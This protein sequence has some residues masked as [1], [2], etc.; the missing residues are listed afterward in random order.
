MSTDSSWALDATPDRPPVRRILLAGTAIVLIGL[1][2][3]TAW[4]STAPLS[5][6]AI[7]PGVV[8]VDTNRKTVQHLEGGIIAE[9]LVREGQAVEAGQVLLRL[10]D[11]ESRAL[12]QMLDDQ[13]A[14]L[15]AQEA[16]LLA[17]RD[18]QKELA[19]PPE[20]EARRAEP[21]IAEIL[22]GQR[23]IFESRKAILD[24]QTSV[25]DQRVAQ[26][27]AQ[28]AALEAQ[29]ASG[30]EQL[31]FIQEEMT[32]VRDLVKRG[33]EKKPRLL[34]LQRNAAYIAGQQGEYQGRIAQ[35]REAIAQADLES[36]NLRKA[37]I[38]EVS[39]ELREVQT[40]RAETAE[41]L[42]TASATLHRREVVARQ[43]G[44]VLNLRYHT[45]GGVVAPGSAI[46][47][48]VPQNDRLTVEAQVRPT[49]IDMVHE[50]L[51][52]K[53]VLSAFKQ[54]TTPQ[55]D[56]TVTSVSADALTDERTGQLYYLARVSVNEAELSR[57]NGVILQPGMPAEVMI[58]S[59]E[60]TL[61]DY[62]IQ[63]ITDSF[64]S[65]FREQ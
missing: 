13:H 1:G 59:E 23:R 52:A 38:Q 19:F 10:D 45:T 35:A 48:I 44:V 55:L 43:A 37:R 21:K 9:I 20:L 61:L 34:A 15:R 64:R 29:L 40:K 7:A 2:G 25:I 33:L 27:K 28:I 50:G 6:A 60:R 39:M 47:D 4:A 63:P 36:L 18:E 24:G 16:R 12:F 8:K 11:L 54:R 22:D 17:E 5:S 3:F 32:G 31:S 41:R 26:L 65:A 42:S 53:V 49:D 56:A 46:L 30:R 58:Q 57:L 14:A 62:L 51:A